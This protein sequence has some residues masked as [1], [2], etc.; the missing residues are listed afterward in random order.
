MSYQIRLSR[1]AEKSLL[2]IVQSL[3]AI[4]AKIR[5][6]IDRLSEEPHLGKKL[7][8]SDRETRRVRVGDY[9]IIYEIYERHLLILVV[10]VG[11]RGDAY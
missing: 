3:P 11:P 10:Y 4:G 5:H 9:R 6:C 8:G 2:K 7:A 1:D